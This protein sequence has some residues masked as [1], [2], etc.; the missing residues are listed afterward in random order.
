MIAILIDGIGRSREIQIEHAVPL[1]F[2]P[3][4]RAD[5]D[6]VGSDPIDPTTTRRET[7]VFALSSIQH[8]IAYYRYQRTED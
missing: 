2:V 8:G 7:A 6:V 4:P 5:F 3:R 1:Y